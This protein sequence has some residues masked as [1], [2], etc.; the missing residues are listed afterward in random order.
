[1]GLRAFE[2]APKNG[3]LI[4]LG[5]CALWLFVGIM[6]GNAVSGE[7]NGR[8]ETFDTTAVEQPHRSGK[9]ILAARVRCLNMLWCVAACELPSCWPRLTMPACCS[10]GAHTES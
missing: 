2:A 8:V 10:R 5:V 7:R 3:R 4:L 9:L 6:G 1:M